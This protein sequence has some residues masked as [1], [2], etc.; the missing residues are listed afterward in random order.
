MRIPQGPC[1]TIAGGYTMVMDP[2][3]RPRDHEACRNSL[4]HEAFPPS[5]GHG[6]MPHFDQNLSPKCFCSYS[7][8]QLLPLSTATGPAS[9]CPGLSLGMGQRRKMAKTPETTQLMAVVG[10][11]CPGDPILPTPARPD[12][13]LHSEPCIAFLAK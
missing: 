9:P 4:V 3:G 1:R 2:G 7:L 13:L 10:P 8:S 12:A 6:L 11:I 5:L